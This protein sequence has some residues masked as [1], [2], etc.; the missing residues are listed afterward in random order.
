[1][2]RQS[3][4]RP[5]RWRVHHRAQPFSNVTIG[6]ITAPQGQVKDAQ[7][8]PKG[9]ANLDSN[10]QPHFTQETLAHLRWM[11]QKDILHQDMFLIGPPGPAR[12][13]LALQ[14][15]EI[16]QREV[17]YVAISQDTTESDLKQRREI[18]G[19]SAIFADQ[20]PVRAAI[21]GRIL[22]LDGLEKAERNVLPTLNNLLENREMALD[23]GRFLMNASSYDALL[24]KGH[25]SEQLTAQHLVRV[26]PAFRVI[27]LGLPVP[28]YPGRTLDPPLRSRFQ[29]RQVPPL[30]PGAQLEICATIPDGDKLVALVNAMHLIESGGHADRM[31]HLSA[32]VVAYC[33][34]MVQLFPTAD[35]PALLRRRFPLHAS[36]AWKAQD[37]TFQNV[38]RTFFPSTSD[39]SECKYQL[40]RVDQSTAEL[41]L[42]DVAARGVP[43]A[44]GPRP[45][46]QHAPHFVETKAHRRVLVAM[47]QDHAAGTDMCVVGPKGSGKSALARQ[48]CG[49]LGYQSDLFTLFQDMTARDLFQ[50]RATDLHGNTTWEDSPLLRAARHGHVVILDGVHRLSSDTL[51]TLQRLIQD[52]HVDLA[53]GT[54]FA[55]ADAP[56]PTLTGTPSSRNLVRIHPAFRIVALGEVAKPWLTSETM[57]LFPFH[58]VPELTREDADAVVAAL[59][60]RVP[61]SVSTKLVELWHQVQLLPS[62]DLS[63]SVRQLLR[64]ARRLNAFPE[65]AAADLRLLIEDTTMMHFLPNA[66]L[67]ADVLD[68]CHIRQGKSPDVAQDLAI[69]DTSE[70]LSIGHVTYDMVKSDY[71]ALELIPHPLYFN[72]PKHTLVMQQMLQDIVSGQP[73]LLLIGNQGV[74]KN[75]VVDRLLQLMHQEREYIQLH[76]DTTVQTLTMVPSMENGRIRWEDSPLVRAV[77]F[78]R[79]LVVDEADKAPLE[80]VCVLKGLIED[81]E[82]LLGDGRRIVDRAKGTFNDDHDDDGSVICIHPRF[83]LWVLA[84]R[85]GYPFLGNNFFS[86]VGDIFATHVLDNPDPASEL[87]LL[88]S[89]APNVST[90]VLMKLCAAFSELR[91]MVE[92]GTMT[93]PYST[94]E[95]VAIAKHLEAFPEDGVAYTLENVLAF[96]G[97]D[98]ALRQRLRDVFG[99]HGIPL[100]YREPV[101]PTISLAPVSPLPAPHTPTMTWQIDRQSEVVPIPT[102]STL[103][104]RRIYIEPPTS[105]TFA[106]T[107]GRLHTFSEEFCSWNVPLWT[108]QTAVA[109]AVLP[110]ASIHVLTKQPLGIHSYFGAN[111]HERLHLYSELE[112]YNQSKTEAHLMAWKESL[113]LHVPAEDLLIVLSKK[114]KVLQ[115]RVLPPFKSNNHG[116]GMFQWTKQDTAPMQ[117]L[118]GLLQDHNLLVRYLQGQSCLQV[119]DVLSM[120]SYT[121]QLPVQLHHVSLVSAAEWH[122]HDVDGAMHILHLPSAEGPR[123]RRADLHAVACCDGD[124][125]I[126][127]SVHAGGNRFSHPLAYLQEVHDLD[128]H[129]KSVT[130]SHRPT[131]ADVS[132][133]MWINEDR[134]MA[135]L[136]PSEWLLEVVDVANQQVQQIP[137]RTA[138]EA[139]V[140]DAAV[141]PP[142]TEERGR[143]VVSVQRDGRVR[144]WQVDERAL[145]ADL[146]T[147]KS[148][149]DYHALQGTSPYLELQYNRPDGTSEPKTGTS[150]PKHGKEDPDNTPHVGGN[151]WAGGSGGSDTAGLGGRGGPYRL[152]KG[153]R[154]HQISQLQKDQVTKEAQE[155]AKA[156]AD[157]ALADQLSQ[158][159]MTNHEL[160][161]YQQYVDRVHGE[162]TQLRDL[163]HN[164]EQLADERGWLKHQ[165]SG[166][167]DDAKLVDGLSGDRNVF[168]R[169]GRDPFASSALL[170]LPKKLLFVM[171]VSGS[172]YRFNSQDISFLLHILWLPI[173]I[174]IYLNHGNFVFNRHMPSTD[175][176]SGC[177]RRRSCSWRA[178]QDS[179]LN[180]SMR[181]WGTAVTP[182]RFRLSSLGSPPTQR[183]IG[184]RSCKKW[185]RT[186]S[187]AAAATTRW[188]QLKKASNKPKRRLMAMRW[189]LSCRTPI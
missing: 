53:D 55:T 138:D 100:V 6:G 144:H 143:T 155:K 16:M 167:W 10:G 163:F 148:M 76:R 40:T 117:M 29:A 14:F 34:K 27:A 65:S 133:S 185:S 161:S 115:S 1:M 23:D 85:P 75:K 127:S 139:R 123:R 43:V 92:D 48:F 97:Y 90:D 49:S 32:S 51:S 46:Q 153:H 179:T 136:A 186:R 145:Q 119:I 189:C 52:R 106:V 60:P 38:L 170:P 111:T 67:M 150:L 22:I 31:P 159:D 131:P 101:M 110:D 69:V 125:A 41:R 122:V 8:V 176:W 42:G 112:S 12:R 30:S 87:A 98:A 19:G 18:L 50:R 141:L 72:I 17:E 73:H 83:R 108:R 57:A 177:W 59:C 99:R 164:V 154:V 47:L 44:C 121:L 116:E 2:L 64:L 36:S 137:F 5:S 187:I 120:S 70:T 174:Y 104:S 180:L 33:T 7:L 39:Q 84:N 89:Y 165:S 35:L 95:A 25:T 146:A 156:M 102:S 149:F 135:T 37:Q 147:W 130:S 178:W 103:K 129:T 93:Y 126:T 62:S 113:V 78:G 173:Y 169:R 9:F 140:A 172:M 132:K 82:M 13:H 96:D 80:V 109:L 61:R 152:D 74:G 142:S 63:L 45:L 94:R 88:Q 157:A 184:S 81:G 28:P 175:D 168:K 68:A 20:A 21:H 166:E 11:L 162:T 151:T 171:D 134:K 183:K 54:T 114:H 24:S 66:Q 71:P 26:D 107:P 77:K 118:S 91:S 4:L 158:I 15:C 182:P 58:S 86:E 128:N 3:L 105:H 56:A 181:S 160:A 188:K 79:T 124:T